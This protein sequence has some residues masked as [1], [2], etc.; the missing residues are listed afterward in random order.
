MPFIL[1]EHKI[2]RSQKLQGNRE[3]FKFHIINVYCVAVL[4]FIMVYLVAK[5]KLKKSQNQIG[6]K[7][8]KLAINELSV[9]VLVLFSFL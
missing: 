8:H 1:L 3:T 4:D 2:K 5:C 7:T 6:K 9:C